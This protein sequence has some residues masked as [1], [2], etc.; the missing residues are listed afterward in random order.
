MI[1]ILADSLN[2]N[3]GDR[4]TTFELSFP[5]PLLAE[6]NT[7]RMLS[8]NAGSS[9]AI[10]IKKVIERVKESP[11][12]PLFTKNQKGMQGKI[13]DKKFQESAKKLWLEALD[14]AIENVLLLE[15]LGV[16]K[17]N[18][19]R[20]LE[21]WMYVPVIVTG[22]EW[23]NFFNLRCAEA[24]HPDFRKIAIQIKELYEKN[25]PKL[26]N[27]GEWHI[28]FSEGLIEKSNLDLIGTLKIATARCAR[29]SYATHDGVFDYDRDFQLHDMLLNDKHMS[30][31]EHCA[32]TVDYSIDEYNEYAMVRGFEIKT[33]NFRGFYSYRS[34]IE[35][36]LAI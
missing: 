16:H 13:G 7:H 15:E 27:S 34:H 30:P 36:S 21:P 28:P 17:Q 25:N 14:Q 1:K 12:I 23:S 20:I 9:R 4:I 29:I 19:N 8:K 31:F 10:P 32:V 6:M 26:L 5:R 11:Y 2:S 35:D 33:R 18:T 22:T 3:T 24:T